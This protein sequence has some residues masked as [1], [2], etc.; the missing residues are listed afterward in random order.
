MLPNCSVVY[1]ITNLEAHNIILKYYNILVYTWGFNLAMSV[2]FFSVG[3]ILS[4][5]SRY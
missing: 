5:T 3:A 2:E 1:Y 4:S